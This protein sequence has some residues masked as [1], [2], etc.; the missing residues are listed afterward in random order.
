MAATLGVK[1]DVLLKNEPVSV[2]ALEKIVGKPA[3]AK[4]K[5]KLWKSVEGKPRL[6]A[7]DDE[8]S[9]PIDLNANRKKGFS[10]VQLTRG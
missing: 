2:A 5:G 10:A 9:R 6:V 7:E 3:I 8:A 1:P 4:A